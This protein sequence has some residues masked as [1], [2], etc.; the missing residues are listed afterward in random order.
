LRR[1]AGW[2][3]WSL[4][5]LAY[6]GRGVVSTL[7][8]EINSKLDVWMLGASS[9]PKAMVGVYS[10]AAALNEGAAQL[11]VV[12]QNNVNPMLAAALATGD[13]GAIEGLVRR[14]RRWFVPGFVAC[15]A[16]G[17]V[18]YPHV[19]PS[20]VHD[21]AFAAGSRP[22]AVLMIGLCAASPYLP[23]AQILLMGDRPGWH[24]ALMVTMA[25]VNLV[26]N[27]LLIPVWGIGGAAAATTAAI[28]VS[29]VLVRTLARRCVGVRL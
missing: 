4:A 2:R 28:V 25:S 6:G 3:A 26:A 11:A 7:A 5:H 21:A 13:R 17:A 23:F 22:F 8:F 12:V 1:G 10:L 14:T 16:L 19:I 27:L 18:A 29:A 24:T 9:V 15:C 20:V